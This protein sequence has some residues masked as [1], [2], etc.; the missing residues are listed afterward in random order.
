M[1]SLTYIFI[2]AHQDDE[3]GIYEKINW[4][5]KNKKNILIF[6]MTSGSINKK[7]NKLQIYF[8][9]I[10]SLKV[11]KKIGVKKKN[12]IFFGRLN[13]IATCCLYKKLQAAYIEISRIINNING[14]KIIYTHAWEGGNEDHDAC[15]LLTKKIFLEQKLIQCCYQFPLYNSYKSFLFPYKVQKPLDKNG[16]TIKIYS[17]FDDRFKYISYLFYYKSQIKV[18]IGLYP[19]IIFNLLFKGYYFLQKINKK[20]SYEKPHYGDLLYEKFKRCDYSSF[21]KKLINFL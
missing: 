17:S 20:K 9:D 10:E 15:Y 19:F 6:Y 5:V 2:L 8:R 7:I 14:K 13:N 18:W 11:L 3:F 4:C 21:R 16:I 12:I 1:V